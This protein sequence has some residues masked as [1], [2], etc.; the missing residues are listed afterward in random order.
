MTEPTITLWRAV[1]VQAVRDGDLLWLRTSNA[2]FRAV[3]D[4]A[5][6][7]AEDVA[8]RIVGGTG[9]D[10]PRSPVSYTTA[11]KP[12]NGATGSHDP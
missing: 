7:E 2:D 8:S 10:R 1:I 5:G 4:L 9:N 12:P 3:C 6:L 11:E